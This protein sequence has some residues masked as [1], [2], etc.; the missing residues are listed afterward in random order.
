ML[1]ILGPANGVPVPPLGT[2]GLLLPYSRVITVS[3]LPL[4]KE[5]SEAFE[6]SLISRSDSSAFPYATNQQTIVLISK[7]AGSIFGLLLSQALLTRGVI[8]LL[9]RLL[10]TVGC[11]C[12]RVRA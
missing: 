4:N 12:E 9:S 8:Q 10:G 2:L 5:L 3:L 7:E 11:M 1:H 6:I